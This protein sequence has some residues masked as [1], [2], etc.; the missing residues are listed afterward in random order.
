MRPRRV[1]PGDRGIGKSQRSREIQERFGVFTLEDPAA[2][3]TPPEL[4]LD[5][6]V[7]LL[8][9]RKHAELALA[10]ASK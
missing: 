4:G 1:D 8:G 3:E 2:L 9:D 7:E 10:A 6:L 5:E